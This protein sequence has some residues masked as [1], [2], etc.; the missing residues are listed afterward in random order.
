LTGS[1]SYDKESE[2]TEEAKALAML[3]SELGLLMMA[4]LSR[5]LEM[6]GVRTGETPAI[7]REMMVV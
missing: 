2:E 5:G 7:V 1:E 6:E 3:W 4:G